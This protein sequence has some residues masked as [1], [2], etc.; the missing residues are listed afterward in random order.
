MIGVR[1]VCNKRL[2]SCPPVYTL[3]GTWTKCNAI[4]PHYN[5]DPNVTFGISPFCNF[6]IAIWV[7]NL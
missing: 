1:N 7:W 4:I 3:P 6:S 2:S 5:A